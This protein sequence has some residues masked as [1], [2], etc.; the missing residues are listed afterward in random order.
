MNILAADY[1]YFDDLYVLD[2]IAVEWKSLA[3]N[4]SGDPPLPRDSHGVT[5]ANGKLYVHG[6]YVENSTYQGMSSK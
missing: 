3:G 2:T 6:G 1:A 4:V 5:V